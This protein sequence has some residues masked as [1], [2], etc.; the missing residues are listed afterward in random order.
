MIVGP[1]SESPMTPM[2]CGASASASSSWK[3]ACCISVAPRPP[4]CFGH[5]IPA[6]P[7]SKSVRCQRFSS[8]TVFAS[9]T[10]SC[11]HARNSSR[12]LCSSGVRLRSM[13]V[14]LP[15]C[16]PERERG[17]WAGG[18]ARHVHRAPPAQ[19]PRYARDDRLLRRPQH[20]GDVLHAHPA[21]HA[22]FHHR[23]A[24]GAADGERLCA[25]RNGFVRALLIH[26]LVRRLVDEAHAASA[27]ATERL[28]AAALH[29][30]RRVGDFARR[31]VHAVL[32]AEV[33]G[34]VERDSVF[35]R[36]RELSFIDELFEKFA[37]VLH[38]ERRAVARLLVLE[39]VE[40]VRAGRDDFAD[41]VLREVREV[42]LRQHLEEKLVADA[43]RGI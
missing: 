26:A 40:A 1:T 7:P 22:V 5:E 6:H 36:G 42:V 2:S 10:F 31:V 24:E 35:A 34:I 14:L 13:S 28:V 17:T 43:A 8:S 9:N 38:F 11:S 21:A 20:F 15:L 3:T 18:A 39:G 12:K 16:H 33:A 27:A 29:L 41:V 32:P 4:Y 23:H 30:D 19:V 25:G 37:V